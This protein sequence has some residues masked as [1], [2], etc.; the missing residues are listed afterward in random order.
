M[1]QVQVEATP[2][3]PLKLTT[4]WE[5]LVPKQL[6]DDPASR[7]IEEIHVRRYD[8]AGRAVR[9]KRV[10]DIACG[11]GYGSRMLARAGAAAVVGVDVA[12]DAVRYA[13]AHYPA[14]GVRF[15]CADAERFEWPASFDVVVSFETIEHLHDPASFLDRLHGLLVPGGTLFLSA[16]LGETRH[17][18]RYHRHA[19]S[20]R[21]LFA[22]LAGAGFTVERHHCDDWFLTRADLWRWRK[23]YPTARPSLREVL[24]TPRGWRVLW[25]SYVHGGIAMPMLFVAARRALGP[26]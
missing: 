1:A 25:D 5:R 11:A 21:Q 9:G 2:T 14:P 7:R 26:A 22:L 8:E 13:R 15:V 17:I 24:L 18:D 23:L 6:A 20:A 16:P 10:L 12:A 3:H 4:T 19:F